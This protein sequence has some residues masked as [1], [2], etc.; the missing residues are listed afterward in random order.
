[1]CTLAAPT[2]VPGAWLIP[3]TQL[4]DE[5]PERGTTAPVSVG[6]VVGIVQSNRMLTAAVIS[7]STLRDVLND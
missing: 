5:G 7:H 4:S 6:G 2:T 1:M 3:G